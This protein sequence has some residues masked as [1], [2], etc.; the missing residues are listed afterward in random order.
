[1]AYYTNYKLTTDQEIE[2]EAML[3]RE[4]RMHNS[5]AEFALN[6]TGGTR[7]NDTW[8]QHEPDMKNFSLKYPSVLFTLCGQGDNNDDNWVKYFKNGKVQEEQARITYP[9]F[10]PSKLI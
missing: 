2:K 10:D 4:L 1:M 7:S 5:D 8:Y 3:V 6:E 9:E